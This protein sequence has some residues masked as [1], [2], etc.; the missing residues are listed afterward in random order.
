VVVVF[1]EEV[2]VVATVVEVMVVGGRVVVGTV[3]VE[4]VAAVGSNAP[5]AGGLG[6]ATPVT[7]NAG[8]NAGFPAPTAGAL[9][10]MRRR[11]GS[12]G[13]VL[14]KSGSAPRSFLPRVRPVLAA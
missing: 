5:I 3:V 10:A 2:V 7:S 1:L 11:R 8:A 6:R 9:A 4:T 13:F 12:F 14:R